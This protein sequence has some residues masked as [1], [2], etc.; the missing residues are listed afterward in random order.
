MSEENR[1]PPG[2]TTAKLKDITLPRTTRNP[3]AEGDGEF[4][5]VDIEALDNTS[6]RIIAPKRLLKAEAPSRARMAIKAGDIIF[7]LV[8][9]YL[10]NLAVV[11]EELDDQIAS[12]AY[13]VLRPAN[14]IVSQFVFYSVFREA[15][16]NLIVTY[17]DSPPAGHDDEF[18]EM[19]IP[20][21]PTNE[22]QRIVAAIEQQFTRLDAGVAALKSAQARLKR[23][24]AAVLKAAV[25]GKLTEEWRAE[26]PDTEPASVLLQRILVERRARWEADLRAKGKDP[27]KLRYEEPAAPDTADLPELLEGWR[28][29]RVDQV[30]EVQLGRQRAPQYHT[31]SHMRPYLRVANVFEDRIDTSDVMTMNFTPEEYEIYS[32]RYGDILLNEG[33]SLELVGRPAMY[34]DEVPGSCFQNT[35]VRFRAYPGLLPSFA[36]IVFRAYLHSQRFQRI[37][38][39]TT[40]IAHLG[41]GRFAEL[42]FPLPPI[43]EQEQIVAELE[44]RLSVVS[45]LEATV[46][47]NL[48]R[49]ERLRQSILREA[50]AGRLVPKDPNDEPASVLLERIR[51]ERATRQEKERV[52]VLIPDRVEAVEAEQGSLW[53]EE[54]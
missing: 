42:E 16:I 3:Q 26:H 52:P 17:G 7:S 21:A 24:R 50:F 35:L 41:A 49:A 28:W 6:Q 13:C 20:L 19:T 30:G 51:Q 44:Q 45:E 18:V 15:F 48:K 10:K 47:A 38:K 9:P 53:D 32:L 54:A 39:H 12:T 34:R 36:L 4:L 5:Y 33:Q 8:R 43:S 2:W 46:E 11:P 40:N 37:G 1:L 25:E 31:G 14:G 27:T 23:Y 29:A 22:Q